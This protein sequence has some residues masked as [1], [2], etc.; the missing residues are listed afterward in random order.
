MSLR[1]SPLLLERYT[2]SYASK[3]EKSFRGGTRN[4]HTPREGHWLPG[5]VKDKH[6]EGI[7]RKGARGKK[8]RRAGGGFLRDEPQRKRAEPIRHQVHSSINLIRTD[9]LLDHHKPT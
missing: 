4:L 6:N 3:K 5:K 2:H 8:K 9:L 7:F 1:R